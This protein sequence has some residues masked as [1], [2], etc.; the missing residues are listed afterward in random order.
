M[1]CPL[2]PTHWLAVLPLCALPPI[3][4]VSRRDGC[5]GWPQQLGLG[6]GGW[7][8]RAGRHTVPRREP[9]R[10]AFMNIT[11]LRCTA[12]NLL[13]SGFWLV[14]SRG[15]HVWQSQRAIEGRDRRRTGGTA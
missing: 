13:P 10:A 1:P 14:A 3:A 15:A 6:S 4:G 7:A 9:F 8:V 12:F 11:A 5:Q 2:A